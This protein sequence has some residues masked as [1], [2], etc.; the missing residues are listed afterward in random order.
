MNRTFQS[1]Q[2][3]NGTM[4]S[5]YLKEQPSKLSLMNSGRLP[6]KEAT[7]VQSSSMLSDGLPDVV[8]R[9]AEAGAQKRL[10]TFLQQRWEH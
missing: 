10:K 9:A 3:K 8:Q 4:R 7:N 1:G 2:S 6:Q 5:G